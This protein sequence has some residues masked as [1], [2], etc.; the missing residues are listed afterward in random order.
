M[1]VKA[2]FWI[3]PLVWFIGLPL[4]RLQRRDLATRQGPHLRRK[5][6]Q[7]LR[8]LLVSLAVDVLHQQY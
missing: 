1:L 2:V 6:P 3:H 5:H 4:V 8:I 7:D